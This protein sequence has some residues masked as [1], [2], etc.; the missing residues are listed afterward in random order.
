MKRILLLLSF[1]A[2]SITMPAQVF[3]WTKGLIGSNT[4]LFNKVDNAGNVITINRFPGAGTFD[5]DP[6]P[7]I[8]NLTANYANDHYLLKLNAQGNFMWAQ[9]TADTYTSSLIHTYQSLTTDNSGNIYYAFQFF[10]VGGSVVIDIDPSPATFTVGAFAVGA[11]TV[12]IYI[13]KLDNA[14]NFIHAT[15]AARNPL[16]D[17]L[18]TDATGNLFYTAVNQSTI[19]VDAD[20]GPSTFTVE[21][22]YIA[23][24][25]AAG[26]YT[27]VKPIGGLNPGLTSINESQDL[28]IDK[29]NN[30]YV[31]GSYSG[32]P[33]FDPGIGT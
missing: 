28:F 30:I 26:N 33:D 10:Q 3:E 15:P 8:F 1:A 4:P 13:V 23:K 25:D 21:G 20:P 24:L 11:S 6:G 14:G 22:S 18:K 7:G 17:N 16:K 12:C 5:V 32:T 29:N 31:A 9:K 19:A 27:W 2:I